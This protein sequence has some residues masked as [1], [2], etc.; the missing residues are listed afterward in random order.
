MKTQMTGLKEKQ[1]TQASQHFFAASVYDWAMTT[2]ERDLP[3][4][5][6]YMEKQGKGYNLFLVP[7]PH[8][9]P[10]EIN[11]FQPQVEGTKWLGF[12]TP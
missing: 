9:T 7:V 3:A 5:I 12:F 8:D 11:L 4:L 6:Q 2:P 1:A 10:Y